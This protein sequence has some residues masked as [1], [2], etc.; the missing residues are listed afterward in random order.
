MSLKVRTLPSLPLNS[1][2]TH[3]RLYAR[4]YLCRPS[5]PLY[6]YPRIN[7]NTPPLSSDLDRIRRITLGMFDSTRFRRVSQLFEKVHGVG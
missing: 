1:N 2:Y 6:L 4:P 5:L 7:W 3:P